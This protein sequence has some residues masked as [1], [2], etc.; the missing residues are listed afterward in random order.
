[1]PIIHYN[2]VDPPAG[3]RFSILIPTWNN[4]D[5]LKLCVDSIR[6]QSRYPHQVILHVNDGSDGTREWA[7]RENLAHSFSEDNVGIC[8]GMNAAATL[9]ATDYIVY[10]ND[11]M[12]VCPDWDHYLWQEIE[13]IRDPFF[14]LAS[15]LIE[16]EGT[17]L[18]NVIFS[19]RFGD[20][21]ENFKEDEL[22]AHAQDAPLEDWP[23]AGGAAIVL[24]R[25][26]WDL[27]GGYSVEFSPGMYSDSDFSMKL[28]QAGVRLFK[29]V[30]ASRV[31]HFQCRTINKA[32][33]NDGRR[34]FRRKWKISSKQFMKQ[35][36]KVNTPFKG[37]LTEPED[38][39][40]L[41]LARL[42]GRF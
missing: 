30:A 40:K 1:M 34:Q 3:A 6:K 11:D 33:K 19:D 20:A 26:L 32:V 8:F 24:P 18:P 22:I 42:R 14:M 4:L 36:L 31:F 37:P 35:Y 27:V 39:M 10:I 2:R 16:P 13:Q 12:Y 38:D 41:K 7:A 29:G 21:L 28:W 15:A 5:Y 9:A 17:N 25:R 23:G